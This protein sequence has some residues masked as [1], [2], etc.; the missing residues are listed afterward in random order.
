MPELYIITGSNGAGK[1]SLGANYLPDHIVDTCEVFDGDKLFMDKQREL[2]RDGIRAH[3]EMRRIAYEFVSSTFDALVDEAVHARADFA[4]EGHFTNESTWDIPR[5]FKSEGY[6]IHLIYLGLNNTDLSELRVTDRVKFGGHYV[7]PITVADNFYG[8][9]E[10]LNEHFA[11][12]DS[13]QVID[14]SGIE[15]QHVAS[16][17]LGLPVLQ[18]KT[19][20]LP[21]WFKKYLPSMNKLIQEFF[22]ER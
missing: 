21:D 5:R 11:M 19:T 10:K 15:H 4:Y 14:T 2:W 22:Y 12:F 18:K 17:L 9:L 3:K 20:L 7:N 6:A 8:N 1:S 13:V 16:F